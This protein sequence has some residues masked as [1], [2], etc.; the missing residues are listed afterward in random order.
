MKILKNL[1]KIYVS[2]TTATNSGMML[3]HDFSFTNTSKV[4]IVGTIPLINNK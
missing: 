2:A 3:H 1:F 4:S